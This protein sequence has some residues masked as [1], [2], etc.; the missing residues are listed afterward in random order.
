MAPAASG[1]LVRLVATPVN[2]SRPSAD[3]S[4]KETVIKAE[5]TPA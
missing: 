5:A 1:W 4:W 3:P 2:T